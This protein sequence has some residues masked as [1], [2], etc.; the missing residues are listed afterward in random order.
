MSACVCGRDY[1]HCRVCGSKN[2]YWQQKESMRISLQLGRQIS[3]F[4]CQR[5]H[6]SN[7]AQE[8]TA[9]PLPKRPDFT[10]GSSRQSRVRERE[11]NFVELALPN[12]PDPLSD[13]YITAL[14]R[15]K[16]ELAATMK[17]RTGM[18][19]DVAMRKEG[20]VFPDDFQTEQPKQEPIT[21]PIEEVH[22]LTLDEVLES[23]KREQK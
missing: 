7:D 14:A 22:E 17:Y 23:M 11:P 10:A 2:P 18:E 12:N 8:C 5:G 1:S 16:N 4:R 9:P 19:L 13:E 6:E 21:P 3:Q 15:R 20:W